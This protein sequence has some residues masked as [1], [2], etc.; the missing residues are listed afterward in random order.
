M[1]VLLAAAP[2]LESSRE[3]AME[4]E[5]IGARELAALLPAK[6]PL[7]AGPLEEVLPGASSA[8]P[9][10]SPHM[11][12]ARP[13]QPDMI[14]A[15]RMLS[16]RALADPRSRGTRRALTELTD[17]ERIAQLCDLEAM[18]QIHAW[19]QSFQPDRLVDYARADARMQDNTL[20]ASG[21][22]FRSHLRWFEVSY[23]C[24]LDEG[25]RKVVG[26]AFRVGDEIPREEWTALNLPSRH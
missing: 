12:P 25:M 9:S 5:V 14:E 19:R 26:F 11:S 3:P 18:E 15:S 20:I 16:E 8:P 13:S 17:E 7:P 4:V 1:A 24:D 23:R 6:P 22:A 21:G 2:V 10:A